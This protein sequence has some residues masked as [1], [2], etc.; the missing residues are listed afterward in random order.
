MKNLDFN[1]IKICQMQGKIFE[2]SLEKVE[3][4]SLI[5]IRRFMF[6][7]LT[8]KFDDFSF[9]TIAFDIDDVFKEI[10]ENTEY[11]LMEKQNTVK[12]K[13]FGLDTFTALFQ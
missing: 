1:E 2:E 12:T 10:E 7:N 3:T 4:S 5:F 6:S 8:K 9:L 11:R 13:C